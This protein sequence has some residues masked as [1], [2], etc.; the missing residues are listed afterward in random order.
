VVHNVRIH[1]HTFHAKKPACELVN[2]YYRVVL[3]FHRLCF[4]S[5]ARTPTTRSG[6]HISAAKSGGDSAAWASIRLR[7]L[8]THKLLELLLAIA[9][10][11]AHATRTTGHPSEGLLAMAL[12]CPS[13][14]KIQRL[15]FTTQ[16]VPRLAMNDPRAFAYIQTERPVILTNVSLVKPLVGKWTTDYLAQVTRLYVCLFIHVRVMLA[17]A[18]LAV[19]PI[20][21]QF[22][23]FPF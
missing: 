4:R 17:F 22:V 23:G 19:F 3:R 5:R 1:A 13:A 2:T 9:L 12:P 6:A 20:F 16:Q 10:L 14:S 8:S 11:V 18:V 21:E 15:P 7:V